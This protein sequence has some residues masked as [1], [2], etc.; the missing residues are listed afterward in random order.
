MYFK[1]FPENS[2][3]DG[4]VQRPNIFVK[5]VCLQQGK[6]RKENMAAEW[7]KHA[8]IILLNPAHRIKTLYLK[9][10]NQVTALH[11]KGSKDIIKQGNTNLTKGSMGLN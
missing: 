6:N 2:G 3:L 10:Q 11:S 1:F 8:K 5:S 4:Y 9:S 7:V